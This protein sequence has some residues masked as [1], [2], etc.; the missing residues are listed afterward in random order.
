MVNSKFLI[1]TIRHFLTWPLFIFS[2]SQCTTGCVSFFW[3]AWGQKSLKFVCWFEFWNI[4]ICIIRYL[5]DETLNTK[6]IDVSY[7]PYPHRL[8]VSLCSI[9]VLQPVISSEV[10]NFPLSHQVSAQNVLDLG[11]FCIPDFWGCSTCSIYSHTPWAPVAM[12]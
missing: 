9:F 10:W 2:V 5:R 12:N 4:W 11:V 8:T 7:I 6:F 1:R 3:N